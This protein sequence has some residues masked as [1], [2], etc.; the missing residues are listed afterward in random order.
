VNQKRKN[1]LIDFYNYELLKSI[2]AII[3]RMFNVD[4]VS[5]RAIMTNLC[6]IFPSHPVSSIR[7]AYDHDWKTVKTGDIIY[8]QSSAIPDWIN[9]CLPKISPEIRFTLVSG[10]CDESVPYDLFPSEQSLKQFIE[11]PRLIH[12]FGQ[13]ADPSCHPKLSVIPIG[14][15]YHTLASGASA[16]AWGPSATPEQQERLLK[17]IAKKAPPFSNRELLCYSNFH[18]PAMINGRKY[19]QDRVD[20]LKLVPHSL[21]K[22]EEAPCIR[23]KTWINQ[24]KCKFVL[25]PHGGGHDCHRTWEAIALGCI[26]IIK[27]SPI[28]KLYEDLPVLIVKSW[29]DITPE[30]LQRFATGVEERNGQ[31]GHLGLSPKLTLQYWRDIIHAKHAHPVSQQPATDK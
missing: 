30:L 3:S 15:D 22:F 28:D 17:E 14:L 2:I 13:N 11:D 1:D 19:G 24:A 6:T 29:A 18:F 23:L 25:S 4:Y 20:C 9:R 5:S 31:E 12:W 16:H 21:I 8:I 7:K 26:P 10:D 27:S